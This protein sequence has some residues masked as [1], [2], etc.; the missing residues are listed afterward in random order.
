MATLLETNAPLGSEISM[1]LHLFALLL[2]LVGFIAVKR[3]RHVIH[4]VTMACAT[5]SVVAALA[6]MVPRAI[7]LGEPQI[8]GFILLMRSHLILG[9]VILGVS[10]WIL[11]EW[12]LQEPGPTCFQRKKW[13]LW[14]ALAWILEVIIGML[15]FVELYH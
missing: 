10:L 5:L 1:V 9:V 14:L 8:H 15:L 7:N 13:M 4:G 12:R 11:A 6:V 3:K 2:L